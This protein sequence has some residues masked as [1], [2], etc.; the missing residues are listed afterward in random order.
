MDFHKTTNCQLKKSNQS[1]NNLKLSCILSVAFSG[2]G[3]EIVIYSMVS[4]E[5][6]FTIRTTKPM[7]PFSQMKSIG[8]FRQHDLSCHA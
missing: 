2:A 1:N 8:P 6:A 7:C 3:R 5:V 4:E